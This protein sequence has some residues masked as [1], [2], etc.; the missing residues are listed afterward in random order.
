MFCKHCGKENDDDATFCKSCGKALNKMDDTPSTSNQTSSTYETNNNSIPVQ[1]KPNKPKNKKIPIIAGISVA[2][3]AIVVVGILFLGKNGSK[4]DYSISEYISDKGTSVWYELSGEEYYIKPEE[5]ENIKL[6][7]EKISNPSREKLNTTVFTNNTFFRPLTT[8]YLESI[9]DIKD[10]TWKYD[11]SWSKA[12]F[13]NWYSSMFIDPVTLKKV[14]YPC[15][16]VNIGKIE[17]EKRI[18]EIS[19]LSDNDYA[20]FTKRLVAAKEKEKEVIESSI[21]NS[22]DQYTYDDGIYNIL[23]PMVFTDG[24]EKKSSLFSI[25]GYRE[26]TENG[27]LKS[28]TAFI[29]PFEHGFHV[30]ELNLVELP[31][32]KLNNGYFTGFYRQPTHGDDYCGFILTRVDNENVH[33]HMDNPDPDKTIVNVDTELNYEDDDWI[34]TIERGKFYDMLK[35]KYVV[36]SSSD[37]HLLSS[38]PISE[39]TIEIKKNKRLNG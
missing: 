21:K 8:D 31:T 26:D 25:V 29:N 4:K 16:D 7:K 39:T 38:E 34:E 11:S 9:G 10:T 3:I 14:G 19:N 1:A 35:E 15:F 12:H 32:F 17:G 36:G 30:D 2:V 13:T 27:G 22:N 18:I 37:L 24:S 20:D 28:C 5:T 6:I 33:I 23:S